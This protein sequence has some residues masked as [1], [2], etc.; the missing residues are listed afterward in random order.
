[1]TKQA[2][3][4]KLIELIITMDHKHL[5]GYELTICGCDSLCRVTVWN[6]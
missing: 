6:K 3:M 2:L 5:E 1:M 4:T